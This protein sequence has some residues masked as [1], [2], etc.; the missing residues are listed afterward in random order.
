MSHPT[1]TRLLD[2]AVHR[3]GRDGFHRTATARVAADAEVSTGTLFRHFPTLDELV[4]AAHAHARF[5]LMML[6]GGQ[7]PRDTVYGYVREMWEAL[8]ERALSEAAAFRFCALF[9]ATPGYGGAPVS[10]LAER[11]PLWQALG[12]FLIR[13]SGE[14]PVLTA[15]LVRL[16]EAQWTAAV[17]A[18]LRQGSLRLPDAARALMGRIFDG[19]WATLGLDRATPFPPNTPAEA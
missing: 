15:L 5:K 9:D 14:P 12:P 7:V 19:W 3:Y 16:L 2:A 13:V 18:L 4:H 1:R 8:I 11:L 6:L 17:E 10:P